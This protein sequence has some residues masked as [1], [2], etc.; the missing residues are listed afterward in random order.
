MSKPDGLLLFTDSFCRTHA[1]EVRRLRGQKD[2]LLVK[3]V[4]GLPFRLK[5]LMIREYP[6]G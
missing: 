3:I 2:G 1:S 4:R 5:E 6:S